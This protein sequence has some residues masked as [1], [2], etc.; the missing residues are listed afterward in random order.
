MVLSLA[1]KGSLNWMAALAYI[2]CGGC[3]LVMRDRREV[4]SRGHLAGL[5]CAAAVQWQWR[6]S[7]V[8][9]SCGGGAVQLANVLEKNDDK[10]ERERGRK[11]D[12]KTRD[13]Q[14]R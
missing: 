10:R 9:V 2:G 1:A 11:A 7:S 14:V 13:R 3:M 12:G 8:E 5:S 4:V 6:G